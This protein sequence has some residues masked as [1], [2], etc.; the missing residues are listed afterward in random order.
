MEKA[1]DQHQEPVV[2]HVGNE[3]MGE[4]ARNNTNYADLAED[5]QIATEK[6]Q[7]MSL[8]QGLKLY[9][10]AVL[11]SLVLSTAIIMEGYDVVLMGS[12]YAHPAFTAKYGE[13]NADGEYGIPAAWQAGLSNAMNAGQVL[14]LFATGFLSER[15][16]YRKTIMVSKL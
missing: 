2:A 1:S 3:T 8:L 16:G 13:M 9:P 14:G 6:E 4:L 10:K 15:L 11:W 5:A 7:Q 12:F